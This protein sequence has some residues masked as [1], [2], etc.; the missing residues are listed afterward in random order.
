MSLNIW[1]L[2]LNRIE[3]HLIETETNLTFKIANSSFTHGISSFFGK[4]IKIT[5]PF[6]NSIQKEIWT[7]IEVNSEKYQIGTPNLANEAFPREIYR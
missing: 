3:I 2:Y 7:W 6:L 1:P 4:A 5:K